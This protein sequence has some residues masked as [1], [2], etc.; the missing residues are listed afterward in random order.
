MNHDWTRR[1]VVR[2]IGSGLVCA[3]GTGWASAAS[4]RSRED[5]LRRL[6]EEILDTPRD[7]V[8]ELVE[9]WLRDGL[10]WDVLLGAV[11]LAGVREVRPR[12]VGFKLHAVMVVES[13]FQL[14]HASPPAERLLPVLWNLDDLKNSQARDAEAGD[15]TL[16]APP[17]ASASSRKAAVVELV[18]ALDARDD[19]RADRAVVAALPFLEHA[20]LFEILWPYAL[21][22]FEN[23]GHKPIFASHV[24]RVLTRVGAE[25]SEPAVRSLV[26]GLL[27]GKPGH[28]VEEFHASREIAPRIR[29]GWRA[30]RGPRRPE[31]SLEIARVLRAASSAE[32]RELVVAELNS[33]L[34]LETVWDGVR[35]AATDLFARQPGLLPVHPTTV[36][37]ALH[38]ISS[39]T[40]RETTRRL[41][42][43]QAASW[44]P[45]FR[46]FLSRRD[47]FSME[48]GGID[49]LVDARELEAVAVEDLFGA[50]TLEGARAHLE[51]AGTLEPFAAALRTHLY[52]GAREHHQPKYAA[53]ILEDARS[54]DP[55]WHPALLASA[56]QYLPTGATR[57][58][59]LHERSRSLVERLHR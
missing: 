55:R 15:W 35:L 7:R 25:P 28:A 56:L 43:L 37:S 12:P 5:P 42:L 30:G 11:F 6:A 26:H 50:P 53:A 47:G 33:G 22:D 14:A 39:V 57:T 29:D 41:A 10:G 46:E 45:L 49:P 44:L 18:G 48:R 40:R 52:R 24:E 17:E 1:E 2:T 9:P 8:F 19:E 38:Y 31:R 51:H 16:S 59:E 36:S 54:A 21:R 32:A 20:E 58:T 27:D 4:A 3:G 34:H 23:I 13:V